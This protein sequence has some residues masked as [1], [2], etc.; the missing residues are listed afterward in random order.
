MSPQRFIVVRLFDINK[1]GTEPEKLMKSILR[2]GK[3]VEIRPGIPVKDT[4]G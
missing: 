2:L 1:P 4:N 3:I